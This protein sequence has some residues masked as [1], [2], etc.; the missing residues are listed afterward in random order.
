MDRIDFMYG[1]DKFWWIMLFAC[2]VLFEANAQSYK[3]QIQKGIKSYEQG[4]YVLALH[5]FETNMS[6]SSIDQGLA[7]YRSRCYLELHRP[8]K[9][10]DILSGLSELDCNN[11]LQLAW[12][13][14]LVDDF[15][16]ASTLI[17][18]SK[19]PNQEDFQTLIEKISI[20]RKTYKNKKGFIVQNFGPDINSV[21]RE[22]SVVTFNDYNSLLYTSRN[23]LI[24]K[25][26]GDGFSFESIF[27]TNARE[28]KGWTLPTK[29]STNLIKENRHDATVQVYAKGR[30]MISYHDGSLYTSK[31]EGREWKIESELK[32]HNTHASDTH[33]FI[34]EDKR[35]V[36]FA[37]D[38]R[39]AGKHLD[40]FVTHLQPDSSWS[41][42]ESLEQ[43]NTSF[44]EDSPFVSID[45]VLYFSSRGHGSIGGYDIFKTKYDTVSSSW[46]TPVNLGYPINSVGEDTYYSTHGKLGY[47][48]SS[49]NGGYGSLDIYRL[50][51]FN[52][53]KVEG[54]V[55]SHENQMPIAN[56]EV[57]MEYDSLFVK[58][59]TD[60]NGHY[61]MFMP[62]NRKMHVSFIKDSL[63]LYESDYIINIQFKDE[64]DN[65]YNF[66]IDDN[67][68]TPESMANFQT[69][70]AVTKIK[71]DVKNDFEPNPYLFAVAQAAEKRWTDSLNLVYENRQNAA[72]EEHAL[73]SGSSFIYF[74]HNSDEIDEKG[75]ILLDS[76]CESIRGHEQLVIAIEGHTD[77][78]GN[79][80]Y[81][82]QLSWKRAY[83]VYNYLFLKNIPHDRISISA[84]GDKKP[85]RLQDDE[86]SHA[87]NRRVEI[88][89]F[90]KDERHEL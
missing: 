8:E 12:A 64:N 80:N 13:H 40:L 43:L 78:T 18:D 63:N 60:I 82:Q 89:F 85:I 15:N 26:A 33:C 20:A 2:I 24:G 39:S 3:R 32:F 6:E 25:G 16:S 4:N 11:T 71:I 68:T 41:V 48:T 19:C 65:Y 37:S 55:I 83:S 36:Y 72:L 81:N 30:K 79:P 51:L 28:D 86:L 17:V 77:L 31:L 56:V 57:D 87:R 67:S 34:S 90:R 69:E 49:R 38:F 1:F 54:R 45:G 75:R 21:N 84:V 27:E 46:S 14:Y 58:S 88:N 9:A 47:L 73:T 22:Y 76:L 5:H 61:S 42:P 66:L 35:T 7:Y 70:D 44:D 29:L 10:I 52:Q 53:V 59:Y 74:D 50:F 23:D 62:V